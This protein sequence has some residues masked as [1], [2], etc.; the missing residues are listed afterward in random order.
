MDVLV[1]LTLSGLSTGMMIFLIA[2]G[3]SLIFGLMGVLNFAHGTLFMW[4]AYTGV[5]VYAR[6]GSFALAILTGMAAGAAAGGAVEALTVRRVYGNHVAQIL[7]TTGVM[8]VMAELVK[9]VWGPNIVAVP[10]PPLLAGSWELG[11]VVVVKYRV[12]TILVGLVVATAVHMVITRTRVG[13]IVRAGVQDAEMVQ[14]LGINIRRVFLLVFMAGAALAALGGVMIGPALGSVNPGMGLDYQM[15][16]FIVVVI[17]GLGSFVGSALGSVLVGL[18]GSYTAWFYPD[19]SLAVN[20]LLM[21][22]VLLVK[23]RGLFGMGG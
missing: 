4:G 2:S 3:L 18:A 13:M 11:G 8:L 5:W 20:V 7:V 15:L 22:A 14:A 21:A 9:A 16:A 17:G 19:A 1:N 10:V 6:T 12:F 23:P